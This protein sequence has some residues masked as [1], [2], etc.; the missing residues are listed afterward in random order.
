MG[1]DITKEI[2]AS[3]VNSFDKRYTIFLTE[4]PA[5]ADIDLPS[6]LRSNERNETI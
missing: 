2:I 4:A 6:T 5:F 1:A 3:H